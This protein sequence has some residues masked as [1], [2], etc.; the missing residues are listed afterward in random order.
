MR[1]AGEYQRPGALADYYALLGDHDLALRWMA[2][3]IESR[4]S[5]V[6]YFCISPFMR[7]LRTDPRFTELW[8][9]TGF[10]MPAA[11]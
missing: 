3:A 1:P 11:R 5:Y 7:D 8:R 9:R 2:R 10:P 4:D 6:F